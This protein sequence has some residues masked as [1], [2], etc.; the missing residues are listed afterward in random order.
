MSVRTPDRNW[1]H[2][3]PPF[4]K[5]LRAL[6]DD[7]ERETGDEWVLEEGLRSQERQS[8]LYAQG[9]TRPG[10]IVTWMKTPLWHGTGLAGD[11]R[12][13]R[14]YNCPAS[15]WQIKHRLEP[16]HGL[17]NPPYRK[18]DLGH[19]QDAEAAKLRPAALAWMDAGFPAEEEPEPS[20]R[21]VKVT[22]NGLAVPAE[23][24]EE[25]GTSWG[26]IRPLAMALGI[27]ATYSDGSGSVTLTEAGKV[28]SLTARLEQGRAFVKM[29]DLAR[30]LGLEIGWD[31]ETRTVRLE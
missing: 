15:W 18:G 28:H 13:K 20:R 1:G 27:T 17:T 23:A 9:R 5:K 2:L 29:S 3:F 8:W 24:Y 21:P 19:V 12:P 4:R 25:G 11:I 6:C 30:N 10:Q 14:G 22:V 26:W 16:K 31:P 7:L